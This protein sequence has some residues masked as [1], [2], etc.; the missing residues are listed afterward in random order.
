[1]VSLSKSAFISVVSHQPL[2][3][4]GGLKSS[5][6]TQRITQEGC[7]RAGAVGV[8]VS[9]SFFLLTSAGADTWEGRASHLIH[10]SRFPVGI[11]VTQH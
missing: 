8:F 7:E 5:T 9:N 10:L 11:I 1:M 3:Y 2:P 6:A 4:R